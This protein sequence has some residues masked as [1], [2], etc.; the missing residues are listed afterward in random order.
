MNA[1]APTPTPK[2]F[3]YIGALCACAIL[4]GPGQ[5]LDQ[6]RTEVPGHGAS[7]VCSNETLRGNYGF[8]VTGIR[9]ATHGGSQ[10]SIVGTALTTF[11][12]DGTFDQFD[13]INVNSTADPYQSDRPGTGTYN[14]NSDC[15]GTMTLTAGGV[16]LDLAITVV[17]QGREV[18]TAVVT[19]NVIVSSNGRKT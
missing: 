10:V 6:E 15:S 1:R 19:P 4:S 2:S 17:D 16:T 13:N 7:F 8:T 12:G 9:P 18:R 14:L 5:A 11:H 3:I